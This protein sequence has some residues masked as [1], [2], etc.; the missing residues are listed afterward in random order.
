MPD[1]SGRVRPQLSRRDLQAIRFPRRETAARLTHVFPRARAAHLDAQVSRY[2]IKFDWQI[3]AV[4]A[5]E[6]TTAV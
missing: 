1:Q 3:V 6:G 2:S 4:A 5:V